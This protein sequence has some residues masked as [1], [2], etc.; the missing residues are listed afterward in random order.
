MHARA[1]ACSFAL[2]LLPA[3]LDGGDASLTVLELLPAHLPCP[4]HCLYLPF[5]YLPTAPLLLTPVLIGW[6]WFCSICLPAHTACL[7][8][9]TTYHCTA[10]PALHTCHLPL[11]SLTTL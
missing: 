8:L 6:S 3:L 2:F 5:Y 10:T 4:A 9:S 7:P 11:T 1:H